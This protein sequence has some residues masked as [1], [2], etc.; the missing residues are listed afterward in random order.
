[1]Q[2]SKHLTQAGLFESERYS[3]AILS[4]DKRYRYLLTRTWDSRLPVFGFLCLNPSTADETIDD[5]TVKKC[6]RFVRSWG[7]GGLVISNL[8]AFRATDPAE[9]K[10]EKDPIGPE[11]DKWI[12]HALNSTAMTIAAWGCH[13]VYRGRNLDILQR[14]GDRLCHL[15]LTKD[16]HP[17]HPLYLPETLRPTP[18]P[19]T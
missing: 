9:L 19:A 2:A 4:E 16:N 6:M 7:G 17:S 8:F 14:F 10:M 18:F 11:N 5:P 3:T 12:E 13:G 1:M 15:R